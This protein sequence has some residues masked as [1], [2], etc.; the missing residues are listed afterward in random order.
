MSYLQDSPRHGEVKLAGE[1]EL[2]GKHPFGRAPENVH[3]SEHPR[4]ALFERVG[5]SSP[6]HEA[7]LLPTKAS[8]QSVPPGGAADAAIAVRNAHICF[9]R[10]GNPRPE[11]WPLAPW[12]R[13][14]A[15]L[16]SS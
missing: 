6:R 13:T 16:I 2:W 8:G 7:A 9:R 15:S 12:P 5:R 1:P 10:Y 14:E 4:G 11:R 3:W